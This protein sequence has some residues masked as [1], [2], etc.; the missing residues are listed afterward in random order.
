MNAAAPRRLIVTLNG[1]NLNLL[2]RR[3]P[4]VYGATTLADIESGLE[5]AA[6]ERGFEMLCFQSNYEG[7][8]IE[9]IH[10]YGWEAAGF[11]VNPGALTHYSIALRDALA[12][13]PAP[14]IEVH[15]SNVAAREEFRQHSVIA[16]V[17]RGSIIG[18]GPRGYL[19]ALE[20]LMDQA[21]DTGARGVGDDE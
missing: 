15:I 20:Y 10:R 1:P 7:A 3:E 14:A 17:A 18:L 8:L 19:L 5:A 4:D 21:D 16:A 13:V 6:A 12:A 11:I 9:Q 2:G